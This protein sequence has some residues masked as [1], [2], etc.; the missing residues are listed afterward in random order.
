MTQVVWP[1]TGCQSTDVALVHK[2]LPGPDLEVIHETIM[3]DVSLDCT[4]FSA[5]IQNQ[6]N[7]STNQNMS[8]SYTKDK[9]TVNHFT[10]MQS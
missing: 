6:L 7:K 2:R 5:E 1:P 10:R 4:L 3:R 9:I 8:S